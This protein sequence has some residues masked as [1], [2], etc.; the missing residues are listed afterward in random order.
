MHT[1]LS[2]RT[3]GAS[4]GS[5]A[6]DHVQVLVGLAGELEIEVEGRGRRVGTG[7]ALLVA[8]GERHDFHARAG[9][10]CLV[11]DSS[12]PAWQRCA[13]QP[14]DAAQ[15]LALAT[16]LERALAAGRP[17]AAV[18]GPALLLDAWGPTEPGRA[19]RAIDWDA[20]G[21]WTRAR[22]AQ[23]LTVADLAARVHL[24]PSQFAARAQ[25][26]LG[27]AAMHWVRS[28]RLA[29]AR[30]LRAGGLP[31]ADIARR[32]GYRSPSALTAALRRD[33]H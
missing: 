28:Q 1:S 22:L 27:M 6:H 32:A 19:C 7:D 4:P 10:R 26:E 30:E 3:Y 16:Y 14:R 11:L 9:S 17:L 5:H 25:Q 23:P 29:L 20:L 18:H 2:L 31:V 24:S 8:C 12:M 15:V 33:R 13:P 21:R